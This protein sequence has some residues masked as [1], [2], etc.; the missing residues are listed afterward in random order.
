MHVKLS[1]SLCAQRHYNSQIS[2]YI[3]AS[4]IIMVQH[5]KPKYAVLHE[6]ESAEVSILR[7][8]V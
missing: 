2:Y 3:I 7:L 4:M 5:C 8:L 6:S 1:A